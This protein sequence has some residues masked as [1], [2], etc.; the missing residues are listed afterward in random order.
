M[1]RVALQGNVSGKLLA[2]HQHDPDLRSAF[3]QIRTPPCGE[4]PA[5]TA[6]KSPSLP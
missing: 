5:Q 1:L 3:R 6:S 2:A 4:R